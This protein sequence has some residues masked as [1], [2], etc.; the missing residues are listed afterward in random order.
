MKLIDKYICENENNCAP[1]GFFEK[2]E[3]VYLYDPELSFSTSDFTLYSL[4]GKK[5]KFFVDN[6]SKGLEM[7]GLISIK[8]YRK[9]KIQKINENL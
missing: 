7:Y 9:R 5:Y 1:H 3:I 6:I 8:E 4:E 2:D